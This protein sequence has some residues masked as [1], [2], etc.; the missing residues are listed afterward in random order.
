MLQRLRQRFSSWEALWSEFWNLFKYGVVGVTS[1]VVNTGVYAL[2][3]R[4]VWTDGPRP[5]F[6]I[7]AQ[8]MAALYNFTMHRNWTFQARAFN[9]AMVGRYLVVVVIGTALASIFFYIGHDLLHIY[10]LVVVT[11]TPFIVAGATYFLHRWYTFHPK[12]NASSEISSSTSPSS[13]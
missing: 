5:L 2:F 6:V 7:I 3:S 13:S 11:G 4:V 8:V 12:H 1:V 10:D 9:A